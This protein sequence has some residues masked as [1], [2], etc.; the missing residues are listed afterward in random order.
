MI[1][2]AK[3]VNG[4]VSF[5]GSIVTISRKGV[6]ARTTVG[7]GDKRIPVSSITAVEWKPPSALI[8]GFIGFTI[9]GGNENR[10]T[11]GKRTV[12]AAK[13]E[14]SVV[15]GKSHVEEFD[16]L[17]AAIEAALA[18][19]TAPQ[20]TGG[21]SMADELKKLADLRTAGVLSDAEFDTQKAHLLQPR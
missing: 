19:Q 21:G 6:M 20:S 4:Q 13:D 7:K 12:D 15:V 5:D 3:G 8:R 14:N 10:S 9:P 18:G 2:E 1:Y 16:V 11:F 17:R